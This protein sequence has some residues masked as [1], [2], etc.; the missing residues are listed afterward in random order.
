MT[1]ERV[2][3][4]EDTGQPRLSVVMEGFSSDSHVAVTD[5][6]WTVIPHIEG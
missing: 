5:I 2:G 1:V 6:R 4:I 3:T